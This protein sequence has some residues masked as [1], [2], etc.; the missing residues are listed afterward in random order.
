L[1]SSLLIHHSHGAQ[2]ARFELK[3][4]SEKPYI[5]L[6]RSSNVFNAMTTQPLANPH[7]ASTARFAPPAEAFH[8][9]ELATP[10]TQESRRSSTRPECFKSSGREVFFLFVACF[11]GATFPLI[12]RAS[13]VTVAY[14]KRDLSVTDAQVTWIAASTG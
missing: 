4:A 6:T 10:A 11:V 12:Q 1:T 5:L 14:V 3:L 2:L 7:R 9:I 13:I 8:D